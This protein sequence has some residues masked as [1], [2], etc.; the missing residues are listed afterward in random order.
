MSPILISG[1][2]IVTVAL[3]FY[4]VAILTEQRKRKISNFILFFLTGGVILDITATIFMIVGSTNSP[5]TVHGF[6]G[7]T[8]LIAMLIDT[9]LIWSFRLKNGNE[10]LVP[11]AI[12]MYSLIA[13]LGWV[14]VYITGSL[15][16]MG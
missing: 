4:S 13:Y 7:Y 9:Y 5:F 16:S 12:H 2:I 1:A 8:V 10:T 14:A 11:K 6:I 3:I 15:R